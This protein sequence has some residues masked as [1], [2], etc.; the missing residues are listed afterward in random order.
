MTK[1]DEFKRRLAA[2][3]EEFDVKVELQPTYLNENFWRDSVSFTGPD[4][5]LDVEVNFGKLILTYQDIL[6]GK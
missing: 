5:D 3:M 4:V 6:E 1:N 2:L